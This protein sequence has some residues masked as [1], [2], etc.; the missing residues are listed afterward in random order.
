MCQLN[1]LT[2]TKFQQLYVLAIIIIVNRKEETLEGV[3]VEG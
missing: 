3:I 2:F 1:E